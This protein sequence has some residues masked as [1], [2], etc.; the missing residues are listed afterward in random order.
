MCLLYIVLE[1]VLSKSH[2]RFAFLAKARFTPMRH[3]PIFVALEGRSVLVVGGGDAA[4]GKVRLLRQA[5]ATITVLAGRVNAG[6]AELERRGAI[7]VVRRAFD[8]GDVSGHALVF[9]A[10]GEESIDAAVSEAARAAGIAVNAVDRPALSTFITPA[11]VDRDPVTVAVSSAGT[12]PI[13]ARHVRGRIEA[14]LPPQ[15]GRLAR[16]AERFRGAVKANF[17]D[18]R[19]RRRFWERF[20]DGSI[21][22]AVMAGEETWA[23]EHMIAAVNRRAAAEPGILHIVGTGSGDPDLMP[24]KAVRAMQQA[25]VLAAGPRVA[26]GILDLARRDADRIGFG[27]ALENENDE[28]L[29]AL[30][31]TGRIVVVLV[32]GDGAAVAERVRARRSEARVEFVPGLMAGADGESASARAAIA[33]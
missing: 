9:A 20:F 31:E 25:D 32:P 30:A 5:S 10:T 23:Q 24:L 29:I 14:M 1:Y 19:S 16:F 26:P 2:S 3:F 18:M 12:S 15:F 6:L 4:L 28:R 21:A 22:A 13:L 33:C 27:A 11:I 17:A 8:H 7:S